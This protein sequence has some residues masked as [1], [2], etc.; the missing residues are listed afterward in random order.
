MFLDY[1]F[2]G[3]GFLAVVIAAYGKVFY[4][5]DETSTSS[6]QAPT[7]SSKLLF[8]AVGLFFIVLGLLDLFGVIAM[9]RK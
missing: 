1:S 7:R 5:G 8:L 2:V 3:M 9:S 6:R 4:Y